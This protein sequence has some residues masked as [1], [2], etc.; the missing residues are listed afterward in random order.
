LI[1]WWASS[2]ALGDVIGSQIYKNISGTDAS[3]QWG[4]GFF[5]SGAM[6]FSIGLCSFFFL[7][8]K[9]ENVGLKVSENGTLFT[10]KDKQE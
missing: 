2:A 9:P 6:V 10:R 5:I 7:V 4:V 8:E 1:G 3:E